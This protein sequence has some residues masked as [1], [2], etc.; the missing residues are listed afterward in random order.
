MNVYQSRPCVIA[1]SEE[2]IIQDYIYMQFTTCVYASQ[3]STDSR[4]NALL[5]SQTYISSGQEIQLLV[6]I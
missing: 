2:I 4:Q 3:C 5:S 6:K 1:L